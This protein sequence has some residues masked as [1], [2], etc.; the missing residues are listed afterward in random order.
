MKAK[1]PDREAAFVRHST[2]LVRMLARQRRS[3]SGMREVTAAKLAHKVGHP[4]ES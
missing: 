1:Q 4:D 3:Q 2:L